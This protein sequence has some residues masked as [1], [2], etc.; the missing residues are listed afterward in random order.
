MRAPKQLFWVEILPGGKPL[1][2]RQLGGGKFSSL[3]AAQSRASDLNFTGV[4]TQIYETQEIKWF[5]VDIDW[6][7]A[8]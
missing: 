6:K 7:V 3:R 1:K 2:F 4:K 5:P 8:E